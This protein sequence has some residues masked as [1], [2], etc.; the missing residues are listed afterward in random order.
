MNKI[1]K[2]VIPITL[3]VIVICGSFVIVNK[4]KTP[5]KATTMIKETNENKDKNDKTNEETNEDGTVSN[6][7][8]KI[9][10]EKDLPKW[11]KCN[12]KIG[13]SEFNLPISYKNFKKTT[14]YEITDFPD[15]YTLESMQT[16]D[17]YAMKD[18]KT[19]KITI[20]NN[21]SDSY[22]ISD[23]TVTTITVSN[24]TDLYEPPADLVFPENIILGSSE[25]EVKEKIGDPFDTTG[26]VD[27]S[28]VSELWSINDIYNLSISFLDEKA[29]SITLSSKEQ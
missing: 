11:T 7:T 1:L 3:V 4:N 26:G 23:C 27:S 16:V 5:K 19:M 17:F 12:V 2:I 25:E 15:D 21:N 8:T 22:A 28:Y 20:Q 13:E 29:V 6:D 9:V 18:G 10:K 14:G 24:N